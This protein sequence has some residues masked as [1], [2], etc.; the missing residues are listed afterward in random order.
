MRMDAQIPPPSV[1]GRDDP[2]S[3]SKILGVGEKLSERFSGCTHQQIG[4]T[5]PVELPKTV[6]PIGNGENHVDVITG[7]QLRCEMLQPASAPSALT[8]GATAM[9]ARVVPNSGDLAAFTTF[10]VPAHRGGLAVSN[11]LSGPL[12]I[13]PQPMGYII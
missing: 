8:L 2:R 10:D 13:G 7:Q 1:S 12:S 4:K 6:E 11:P 3:C 5:N 9:S